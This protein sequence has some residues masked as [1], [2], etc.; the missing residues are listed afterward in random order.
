MRREHRGNTFANDTVNW[1]VK[2]FRR[3]LI[4][5]ALAVAFVAASAHATRDELSAQAAIDM[6]CNSV[7]VIQSSPT[8]FLA[9]GCGQD[10]TY[11]CDEEGACTLDDGQS[12]NV[13]VPHD[14]ADDAA[15]DAVAEALFDVACACASAGLTSHGHSHHS[16]STRTHKK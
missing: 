8:Q 7:S 2:L 13:K 10:K 3:E 1:G 12:S 5:P 15:A 14:P 11:T 16:S 4:F 6:H 9:T